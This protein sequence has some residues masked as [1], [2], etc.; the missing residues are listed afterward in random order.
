MASKE[1]LELGSPRSSVA[2]VGIGLLISLANFGF[3]VLARKVLGPIG[4]VQF[5]G[6]VALLGAYGIALGGLKFAVFATD[7]ESSSRVK[8]NSEMTPTRRWIRIKRVVM[9]SPIFVAVLTLSFPILANS[10][11][12]NLAVC[13][14]CSSAL[15][16]FNGLLLRNSLFKMILFISGIGVVAKFLSIFLVK[17]ISTAI[18]TFGIVSVSLASLVTTQATMLA[19]RNLRVVFREFSGKRIFAGLATN[20]SV[21]ILCSLDV[22]I[23]A[24]L[25][26][27]SQA[28]EF[29]TV[30][31]IARSS[32]F[33]GTALADFYLPSLNLV[34]DQKVVVR[35][36]KLQIIVLG[37]LHLLVCL[38]IFRVVLRQLFLIDATSQ[39]LVAFSV[40]GTSIGAFIFVSYRQLAT[41][42]LRTAFTGFVCCIVIFALFALFRPNL[43]WLPIV[44]SFFAALAVGNEL[45]E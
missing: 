6:F 30:G 14:A 8:F 24:F 44:V 13:L 36:W 26:P 34:R 18:T 27:E 39:L 29:L 33:V 38:T 22:W 16:F 25:Y 9:I 10:F 19:T 3:Q 31:V 2:F 11:R 7:Q 45:R 23:A 12:W 41:G 5:A 4:F 32:L 42:S 17:E 35:R 20:I 15:F 21:G 1:S 37:S 40:L 28:T 43:V